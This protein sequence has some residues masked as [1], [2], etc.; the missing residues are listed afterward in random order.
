MTHVILGACA[1]FLLFLHVCT[2]FYT[3][4]VSTYTVHV[5][6]IVR[7]VERSVASRKGRVGNMS[8]LSDIVKVIKIAKQIHDDVREVQSFKEKSKTLARN[9]E[10]LVRPLEVL[11]KRC[12]EEELEKYRDTPGVGNGRGDAADSNVDDRGE[13]IWIS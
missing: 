7:S 1:R 11:E 6:V 12:T 9:I 3:L 5:K 13:R 8:V 10:L 2:G 4:L